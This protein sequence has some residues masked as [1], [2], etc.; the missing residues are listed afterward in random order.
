MIRV[1]GNM[2]ARPTHDSYLSIMFGPRSVNDGHTPD[3]VGLP[4][5]PGHQ[6]C[7]NRNNQIT[8]I[9]NRTDLFPPPSRAELDE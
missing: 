6:Y 9:L 7:K 8:F 1:L 3:A 5:N 4:G 2:A